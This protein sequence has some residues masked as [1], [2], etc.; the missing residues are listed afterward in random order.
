[1]RER[2][3]KGTWKQNGTKMLDLDFN[4]KYKTSAKRI[5]NNYCNLHV[6]FEAIKNT[7]FQ[8]YFWPNNY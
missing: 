4:I 2:L 8:K 5:N 1:M 3:C 6:P 7:S